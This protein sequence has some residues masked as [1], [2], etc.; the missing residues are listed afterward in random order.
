MASLRNK[1]ACCSKKHTCLGVRTISNPSI[2]L[3]LCILFFA[4]SPF[5]DQSSV[6]KVSAWGHRGWWQHL[7]KCC[8]HSIFQYTHKSCILLGKLDRLH[9]M[10]RIHILL[11]IMYVNK[12]FFLLDK[13]CIRVKILLV[14]QN[15]RWSLMV[16]LFSNTR[17]L[18]IYFHSFGVLHIT[19]GICTTFHGAYL[20]RQWM[21]WDK[22]PK[23]SWRIYHI[24]F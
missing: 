19:W 6:T 22:V 10:C 3:T 8:D 7:S 14:L 4:K 12:L 1:E 18:T 2:L 5:S 20:N 16:F 21:I 23:I 9:Y 11:D 17:K 15:V 13:D 24:H